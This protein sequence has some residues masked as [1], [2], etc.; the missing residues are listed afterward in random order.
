M[1]WSAHFC[2]LLSILYSGIMNH[3]LTKS[4]SFQP[5]R[6]SLARLLLP[7]DLPSFQEIN[8]PKHIA[9]CNQQG[10]IQKVAQ[11]CNTAAFKTSIVVSTIVSW[12]LRRAKRNNCCRWLCSMAFDN[13]IVVCEARQREHAVSSWGQDC[14][15]SPFCPRSN[16]G[17]G[18]WTRCRQNRFQSL[19]TSLV[20]DKMF[21]VIMLPKASKEACA[22]L[23]LVHSM[24]G[25][26]RIWP[27]P[28]ESKDNVRRSLGYQVA[29]HSNVASNRNRKCGVQNSK[30]TCD[31]IEC[32][33]IDLVH[34]VLNSSRKKCHIRFSFSKFDDG[35]MT[36]L[37]EMFGWGEATGCLMQSFRQR[38][39]I[40]KQ[41]REFSSKCQL[42][43]R[44]VVPCKIF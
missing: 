21:E 25:H 6:P 18:A 14:K 28:N 43:K 44:K 23:R 13:V 41:R 12:S 32:M 11:K 17:G 26:P 9:V 38:V 19:Q 20:I 30:S 5:P 8:L 42:H 39:W 22:E 16:R 29:E 40:P 1:L 10:A 3:S 35:G 33:Q 34:C 31:V 7:P 15:S 24:W 4:K 2:Y 36:C 37:W 27:V